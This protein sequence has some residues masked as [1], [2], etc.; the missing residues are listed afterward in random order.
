MLPHYYDVPARF[1]PTITPDRK[2]STRI[3]RESRGF[4][5]IAR[6]PLDRRK[7]KRKPIANTWV[8]R[9]WMPDW[10]RRRLISLVVRN[11]RYSLRTRSWETRGKIRLLGRR[12]QLANSLV[13]FLPVKSSLSSRLCTRHGDRK[14]T[15]S[16]SKTAPVI[17]ATFQ[18]WSDRS[19]STNRP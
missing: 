9:E 13:P 17:D 6:I 10:P 5:G 14:A 1:F 7:K 19:T 8:T 4:I 11:L 18:A 3:T 12:E 16:T 15:A 2:R